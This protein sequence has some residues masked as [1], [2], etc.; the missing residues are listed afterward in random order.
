MRL[1]ECQYLCGPHECVS[2]FVYVHV[3][4]DGYLCLWRH[5]KIHNFICVQ[6][7]RILKNI[8]SGAT[9]PI[10]ACFWNGGIPT[11]KSCKVMPGRHGSVVRVQLGMHFSMCR[12]KCFG[13]IEVCY[14]KLNNPNETVSIL[15]LLINFENS[16]THKTNGKFQT[17]KLYSE[18]RLSQSFR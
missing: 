14:N 9:V 17:T 6:P 15:A 12:H 5:Q 8:R 7:V 4:L 2:C 3:F 18:P 16:T 10:L 1:S 13:M 11:T